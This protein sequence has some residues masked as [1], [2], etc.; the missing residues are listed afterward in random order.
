MSKASFQD[1]LVAKSTTCDT[2]NAGPMVG[3]L[4]FIAAQYFV[5]CMTVILYDEL[6]FKSLT[7][8]VSLKHILLVSFDLINL[9]NSILSN[10]INMILIRT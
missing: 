5:D 6:F 9:I 3:L 2:T 10:N 1:V 4:N 7:F 8:Q